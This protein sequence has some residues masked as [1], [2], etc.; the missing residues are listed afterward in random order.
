MFVRPG[1]TSVALSWSIA[2]TR[3]APSLSPMNSV[4]PLMIAEGR[5]GLN[6]MAC[7]LG[8][9]GLGGATVITAV[10]VASLCCG[11]ATRG[12]VGADVASDA[13]GTAAPLM[14]EGWET[15]RGVGLAWAVK[16]AAGAATATRADAGRGA[17]VVFT[18]AGARALASRG[19]VDSRVWAHCQ[20]K[21][22]ATRA[23]ITHTA[24]PNRARPCGTC[25]AGSAGRNCRDGE[26]GGGA[27]C[28]AS[29]ARLKA[30]LIKLMR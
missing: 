16:P 28:C 25:C 7:N 3:K 5:L 1:A 26:G 21:K 20:T 24:G 11:E 6:I 22:I 9:A 4:L 8:G 30:S 12:S 17:A 2:T 19:P 27:C 15:G 10:L 29:F 23:T 13:R 14:G 18:A